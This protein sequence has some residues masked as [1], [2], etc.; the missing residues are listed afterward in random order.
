MSDKDVFLHTVAYKEH[1]YIYVTAGHSSDVGASLRNPNTWQGTSNLTFPEMCKNKFF[2][3]FYHLKNGGV[4][5][6]TC[7]YIFFLQENVHLHFFNFVTKS[8]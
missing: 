7:K 5:G 4:G 1:A 6:G 3:A 8:L 2:L